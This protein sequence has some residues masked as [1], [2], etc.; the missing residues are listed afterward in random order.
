MS[1][2]ESDE[3][4]GGGHRSWMTQAVKSPPTIAWDSSVTLLLQLG[5]RYVD[6]SRHVGD[7]TA[8]DLFPNDEDSPSMKQVARMGQLGPRGLSG[9][10]EYTG[11]VLQMIS[12][13]KTIP[14]KS[15]YRFQ[16]TQYI[17]N[18]KILRKK[19]R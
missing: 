18:P 2:L 9:L 10:K 17:N 13:S 7:P 5:H 8:E 15:M 3:A 12:N 4:E 19:S 11:L 6:L 1:L 16:T 14:E